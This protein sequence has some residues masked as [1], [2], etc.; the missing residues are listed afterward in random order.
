MIILVFSFVS[1]LSSN[2]D[3]FNPNNH[4][5]NYEGDAYPAAGA[6]QLTLN[7]RDKDM[8]GKT[9]RAT[10]TESLHLWYNASGNLTDFTTHFSFVISTANIQVQSSVVMAL[11]SSLFPMVPI[12]LQTLK[13]VVLALVTV[14][15][16]TT[17]QPT[18]QALHL[19]QL[20]LIH[21]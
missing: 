4:E 3:S 21:L 6:I 13:V 1:L 19:L 14:L 9:G 20:S 12:Y 11:H 18:Q 15:R 2:F 7:E 10:Y 16:A 17:R 5:I 8:S